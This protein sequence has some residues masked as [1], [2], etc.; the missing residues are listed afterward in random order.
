MSM[1]GWTTFREMAVGFLRRKIL[2]CGVSETWITG[3]GEMQC[4]ET[5]VWLIYSGHSKEDNSKSGK[6]GVAFMMT[7][8]C[9]RLWKKA[10]SIKHMASARVGAV[11]FIVKD[12]RGRERFFF[13]LH[14][15][16]VQQNDSEENTKVFWD[17]MGT[18]LGKAAPLAIRVITMDTNCSIGV[19]AKGEKD[20]V[21]GPYGLPHVNP[22]GVALKSWM[23]MFGFAAV[24]TFYKRA[25][26]GSDY[27]TWRH[28]RNGTMYQNDH[29]FVAR[30]N[31]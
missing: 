4:P 26:N 10:G 15:Y 25:S 12:A 20:G 14:G 23:A 6:H 7:N 11:Q 16:A 9:Y 30:S 17:D 21:C 28:F 2:C 3:D 1:N 8:Q 24:S 22:A 29:V 13:H 18:V 31:L 19:A 27:G 5:K